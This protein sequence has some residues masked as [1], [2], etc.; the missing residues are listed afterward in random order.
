MIQYGLIAEEV[1]EIFPD[2]VIRNINNQIESVQYH[3][4]PVL[5]LNEMKKQKTTIEN[6][7]IT[8]ETMNE[9]IDSLRAQL[10]EFTQRI[11][12]LETA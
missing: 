1:D 3:V 8:V 7:T 10:Q 4:L 5:L 9:A 6:L 2:I 11:K 12:V